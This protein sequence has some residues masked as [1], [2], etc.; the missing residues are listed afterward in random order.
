MPYPYWSGHLFYRQE[1]PYNEISNLFT[2]TVAST[3][4]EKMDSAITDL[5]ESTLFLNRNPMITIA[6]V[7]AT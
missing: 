5:N 3:A 6:V 7:I 2:E 1:T 4:M